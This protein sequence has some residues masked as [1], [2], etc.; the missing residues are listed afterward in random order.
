VHVNVHTRD[1]DGGKF[2]TGFPDETV[3]AIV[4]ICLNPH[5]YSIPSDQFQIGA[6]I[7]TFA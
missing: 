5:L 2:L 6:H 3:N 4:Q 1:V 7:F